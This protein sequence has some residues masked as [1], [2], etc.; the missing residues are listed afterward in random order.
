ML[1]CIFGVHI[2]CRLAYLNKKKKLKTNHHP[3]RSLTQYAE[4]DQLDFAGGPT[5]I[6]KFQFNHIKLLILLL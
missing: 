4:R 3:K 2:G 5:E 1:L 6:A